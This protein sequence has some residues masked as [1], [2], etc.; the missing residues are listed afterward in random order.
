MNQSFSRHLSKIKRINWEIPSEFSFG[1]SKAQCWLSEKGSLSV[2]LKTCCDSFTVDLLE[3]T[4]V[5]YSQLQQDEQELLPKESL[6]LNRQVV[7]KGNEKLWVFGYSII[8]Q[9]TALNH[10]YDLSIIGDLPLGETVFR[11][12]NVKRDSLMVSK[13]LDSNGSSLYVRRSRLWMDDKPLLVT[14]LF[15]SDSPIYF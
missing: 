1:S 3:N 10:H 12:D 8:P 11:A 7:L 2:L 9:S 5:N 14:E 4:W 13:V 6:Y 15:L